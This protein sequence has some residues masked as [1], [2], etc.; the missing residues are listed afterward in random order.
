MKREHTPEQARVA[1][2]VFR[3]TR[4]EVIEAFVMYIAS[5]G[6]AVPEGKAFV[7]FPDSHRVENE[8]LV[9]LGV[10]HHPRSTGDAR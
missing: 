8:K 5:K 9:T 10:D 2:T 3:L 1:R 6:E 4:K 7:W